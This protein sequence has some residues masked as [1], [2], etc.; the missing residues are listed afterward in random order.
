MKTFIAFLTRVVQFPILCM[1]GVAPGVPG[2]ID[3][4]QAGTDKRIPILFSKKTIVKFYDACVMTSITNTDY[5]GEISGVG[6]KVIINTTPDTVIVPYSKGQNVNWQDLSSPDVELEINRSAY[7]AFKMDKI[8]LKQFL[9]KAFMDKQ[10]TDAAEQQKIYWD[11]LFLGSIYA[12]AGAANQGIAAGKKTA[13]YNIGAA[14]APIGITKTNIID[15]V[16]ELSGVAE[17]QNWPESD[18]WLVLPSHFTVMLQQSDLKDVSMTGGESTLPNGRLG[19]LGKF[20]LY[21][22]NLYT[23]VSDTGQ[24]CYP[25]IFGHKSA[26]CAASQLTETEYFDKLETTFGKGMKGLQ[27]ADWKTVKPESMGILY[28]FKAQ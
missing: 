23:P 5:S 16:L 18:R 15:K 1:L 20:T 11:S 4:S 24:S 9:D 17:E 3:Y 2:S 19:K 6:S 7:F 14:G 12:G 22:T 10:A 21:S 27:V 13:S 25:C 8:D 28:A 26:I